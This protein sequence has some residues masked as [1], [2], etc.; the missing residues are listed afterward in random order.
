M[1]FVTTIFWSLLSAIV[2]L[3]VLVLSFR[4]NFW[5]LRA[6]AVEH[7]ALTFAD[8]LD[9][10]A[11]EKLV[12]NAALNLLGFVLFVW[13]VLA[14]FYLVISFTPKLAG[15]QDSLYLWSTS[16]ACFAFALLRANW[17][18]QL[19][20]RHQQHKSATQPKFG[21]SRIARWLHWMAL[22]IGLVRRASFELEKAIY[23]KNAALEPRLIDQP[24]YVMGLARSGTT[25]ML[26]ILEKVGSFRSPT[27]RNMPFVLSPNFWRGLTRPLR[28]N[29]QLTARAHGDGIAI[30]FD[31][32]ESFEE[33]F[34]RTSCQVHPGSALAYA[35]ISQ[36]TLADFAAYR[37]L[38][39]LSAL[40][41]CPVQPQT[42]QS[43]RYLSKNNNNLIRIQQLSA[44]PGAHLVL[45]IRDPLATAWS[46]YRQHQ[47]FAQIQADDVFVRAYMRWLGHHEFGLGHKPLATGTQH[48]HGFNPTQADYWL[49][50]WLGTYQNL[51]QTFESLPPDHADRI[52]WISHDRMCLDSEQELKRLFGFLNIGQTTDTF[53]NMLRPLDTFDLT[54]HFD[55][56]L[57][58]LT[59]D[60]Y[61]YILQSTK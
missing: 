22:E 55:H 59:R 7:A 9:E 12:V 5:R 19:Q 18:K 35:P 2:M 37:Q 51:L 3:E 48:L 28:L 16:V 46:L 43:L 47:R 40:Q 41:N 17:L 52:L 14:F 56:N 15:I 42:P 32:P 54:E 23:L 13:A 25:V 1:E 39:L 30:S 6:D 45:V 21:Y 44:Q 20:Q 57:I 36:D 8:T 60:L 31:S 11:Q 50:Y 58:K 26:E 4:W 53:S 38:S 29:A 24:V 27:Y 61:R 34:W 10:R 33:V 49:A